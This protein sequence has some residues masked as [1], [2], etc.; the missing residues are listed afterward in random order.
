MRSR[1]VNNVDRHVE[2]RVR[3]L[4]KQR[5]THVNALVHRPDPATEFMTPEGCAILESWNAAADADVSIARATVASGVTTQ[6]HRLRG[7]VERYL[8][9]AGTGRVRVG[10]TIEQEVRPGDVVIIPA[11]ASQQISNTG[12][13]DLVFYC[14]CSPRFRP[15]RYEAL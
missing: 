7:I 15:E 5:G 14:I 12:V 10:D 6:P 8:I 3:I 9:V 2:F 11:G 13:T 1:P 4:I